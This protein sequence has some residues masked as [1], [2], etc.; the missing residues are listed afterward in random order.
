MKIALLT[1][2]VDNNYGGHLQRY[3][4]MKALQQMGL[5]VVHLNMRFPWEKKSKK[6]KVKRIV[7]RLLKYV[8]SK[9]TQK[10]FVPEPSNFSCYL[11][12]DYITDYFYYRYVKHTKRIYDKKDLT[13]YLGFDM[14]IVG[15]DQVWRYKYTNHMYGINTY[16]FDYLPKQLPRMAYGA[17]FGTKE[18]EF[19]EEVVKRLGNYYKLF[20][21]VSV[22]EKESIQ[23]IYNY[24]WE[25]PRPTCVL[26]PTLLLPQ[27]DY[28]EIVKRGKTK[29]SEGNLFC[30]VLDKTEQNKSIIFEISRDR[31]LSPFEI[32]LGGGCS[33][34]QWLR[35]FIDAEFVITDSYHGLL[36]SLLFNKPFYLCKNEERGGMRF[37]NIL[38]LLGITG[39]EN[40]YDWEKIN[41]ILSQEKEHSFTY[42]NKCIL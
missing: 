22:R 2:P 39:V 28:V 34:E 32:T 6:K 37:D 21:N 8:Q 3:A 27:E 42:L 5:D 4:L 26:D 23:N 40:K 9:I 25:G 30:Y 18:N 38:N 29:P 14:F 41:K 7:K 16:F 1:L 19:D 13:K 31:C 12:A 10:K 36:F 20:S 11:N 35:S 17:S 15:S 24:E 33:V